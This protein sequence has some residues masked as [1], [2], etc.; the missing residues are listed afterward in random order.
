ARLEAARAAEPRATAVN[1]PLAM[2]YRQ[3]GRIEEAEARLRAR[4]DL[5]PPLPDPLMREL[6]DLLHSPTVYEARGDRAFARGDTAAAIESFQL[7]L[8]LS[9]ARRALKQK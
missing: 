9:P 8:T 4:G 1:Y 7:A 6:A 2:A 3:V 5:Q